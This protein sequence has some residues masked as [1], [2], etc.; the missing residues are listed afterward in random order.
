MD[1]DLRRKSVKCIRELSRKCGEL[2]RSLELNDGLKKVGEHPIGGGS[3]S[4]VWKGELEGHGEVAIK[5]LRIFSND[6]S[7]SQKAKQVCVL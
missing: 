7:S 4:D 3:F 5:A 6:P 1:D 2:P